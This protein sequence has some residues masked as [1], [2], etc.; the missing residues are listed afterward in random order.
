MAER[1][2]GKRGNTGRRGTMSKPTTLLCK[3]CWK[4]MVIRENSETGEEFLGCS[5]YPMCKATS[6]LPE[7]IRL[8]TMGAKRLEGF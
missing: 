6:P 3:E 7:H 1:C 2:G 5:Q 4:P 8:E